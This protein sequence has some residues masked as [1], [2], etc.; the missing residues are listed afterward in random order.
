MRFET[1]FGIDT[2]GIDYDLA[3]LGGAGE[4]LVHANA[5]EPIQHRVFGA[6]VK[7]ANIHPAG[8]TFV[9][10]GSGKGRAMLLAAEFRFG[11]VI[12]IEFASALHAAASDNI[13]AYRKKRPHAQIENVLQD[14]ATFNIPKEKTFLYFYNPFGPQVL[15]KVA[16]LIERHVSDHALDTF[17]A[18]RNP[19]HAA[20]FDQLDCMETVV[21]NQSFVLYRISQREPGRSRAS[22]TAPLTASVAALT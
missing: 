4:N 5:Y 22:R 3:G 16:A 10:Y 20:V 9:D 18:Y 17:I 13:A 19:V 8:F 1:Q 2:G 7:A 15:D 14:A 11:K 21:R 6:I 12:G